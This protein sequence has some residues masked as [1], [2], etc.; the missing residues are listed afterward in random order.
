MRNEEVL[1]RVKDERNIVHT[2][3]RREAI[4]IGD[5]LCRKCP[6]KHVI[7]GKIEGIVVTRRQGIRRKQVLDDLKDTTGYWKLKQ[8]ALDGFLW[9]IHFGRDYGPVVR[10]T[11][12]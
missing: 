6:I 11:A 8:K 10:R 5:I 2:I 4:R 1:H 7:E 12:E 9:R 3:K